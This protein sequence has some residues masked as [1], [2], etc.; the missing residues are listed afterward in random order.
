L[1]LV[2]GQAGCLSQA[3]TV[4]LSQPLGTNG[5][6]V[7][8]L[9]QALLVSD[10]A[11]LPMREEI[12]VSWF[13][14]VRL[15]VR[16]D[17]FEAPYDPDVDGQS[18]LAWAAGPVLDGLAEN[19]AGTS[20]SLVLSDDE[21]HIMARQVSDRRLRAWMDRISLAPGFGYGEQHV[22]T[23]AIGAALAV[24][25]PF[26]VEGSEHFV[27]VLATMACA[28][29]PITDP[30]TGNLLGAVDLSCRM[31]HASPLM[32]PF[33]KRA[34][35]E[36]E[37]RLLEDASVA[38]RTLREYFL[39]ARRRTRDALVSLNERT[40]LANVV[41]TAKLE[42]GDHKILWEWVAR[43]LTGD[44]TVA[45]EVSLTGGTWILKSFEPIRDGG[46]FVGAS[47]RLEPPSSPR[48][49]GSGHG[50]FGAGNR[51]RFG[52]VSVTETEL[53]VADLVA[54]GLSNR[55][56]AAQLYLSPH[57]VGFHLRQVFRKLEVGS[58]VELTRLVMERAANRSGA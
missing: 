3:V 23:N 7:S 28:A 45:R 1:C 48:M 56:V 47:L 35:W 52:W 31:E 44:E 22:G 29:V 51:P 19:L 10:E 46:R 34:A 43:T 21:G 6:S 30:R 13:R 53:A 36:I 24:Q 16:S 57:T 14:S 41:A 37:Q 2:A 38:E 26:V 49:V 42:P 4:E 18:R 40:M 17:H 9:R 32:L 5:A 12:V 11:P 15:G 50:P 58:R 33:A 39:R 54:Q 8:W 27:D 25:R 20:T 55:Q